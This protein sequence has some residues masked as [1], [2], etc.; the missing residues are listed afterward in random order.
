MQARRF[1][2][3]SHQKEESTPMFSARPLLAAGTMALLALSGFSAGDANAQQI[4][5]IVGPDG[6][7]TFSDKPPLD[8]GTQASA[9]KAVALPGS[10]GTNIAA[11]PFELR[12]AATRFPVTLYTSPDCGPCGTGRAMLSGR[13]I[14]F[15]ERTVTTNEDIEALKRLAGAAS[16]PFLTIGGQQIKGFSETEWSQFLDA[17]GYPKTSQLPPGYAQRPASPM[18]ALQQPQSPRPAEPAR[19]NATAPPPPPPA[20]NPAGIKF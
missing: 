2:L 19:P 12:E 4:Y 3:S 10:G 5:R 9:A 8:N 14:P 1:G 7:V 16:V 18:V 17:A 13:G 6:R 20:E 15:S 11:L